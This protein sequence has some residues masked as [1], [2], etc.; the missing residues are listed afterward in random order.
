MT[1]Q[2]T[3]EFQPIS[4]LS[5]IASVIDGM[6]EAAAETG[7]ALEEARPKPYVLDD[8]TV[9]RVLR[10]YTTQQNDLWLYD[11]QLKRWGALLLTATQRQEVE[12]LVSQLA[13]LRQVIAANLALAN[14]MKGGTI[15][16][17]LGKSDAELGLEFLLRHLPEQ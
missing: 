1:K 8:A 17:V 5:L 12:R 3:P 10:V 2:P 11:E 13:R 15:E 7:Q 6:L 4:Q 14:E 9:N 16:Q